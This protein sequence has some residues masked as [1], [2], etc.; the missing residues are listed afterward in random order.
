MKRAEETSLLFFRLAPIALI[1]FLGIAEP[2][3]AE[4]FKSAKECVAGKRVADEQGKQGK[5]IGIDKWSESM[6]DVVVD[7]TGKERSYIFWMLHDQGGS[8]ETDDKLVSATYACYTSSSS[9][10]LQPTSLNVQISLPNTYSAGGT[11]GRFHVEAESRKIVFENGS[12]AKANGKL[13]KGPNIGLNMDGGSF[14]NTV[15]SINKR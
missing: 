10:Q 12:L 9:G 13:L 14:F 4:A 8:A 3:A 6:C 2:A 11:S 1:A 5:V 15:C 7:E